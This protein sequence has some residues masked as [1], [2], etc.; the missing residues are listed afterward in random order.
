[1]FS[2]PK[3]GISKFLARSLAKLDTVAKRL[4]SPSRRD[5][6]IV[7]W[8][9]VPWKAS[10][11]ESS[12]RVRHDR[13]QLV[14]EYFS[15]KCAPCFFRRLSTLLERF[16]SDVVRAAAQ[17]DEPFPEAARYRDGGW[18]PML[19]WPSGLSSDLPEPSR[20]LSPCTWSDDARALM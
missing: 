11:K 10:S 2:A 1:M 12:R 16:V 9:E 19:H 17:W 8:H 18:K 13:A 4:Q 5:P 15:S 14:P 6:P 3:K 20:E 7:A